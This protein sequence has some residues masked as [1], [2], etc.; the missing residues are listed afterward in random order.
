MDEFK[1]FEYELSDEHSSRNVEVWVSKEN[2]NAGYATIYA[3]ALNKDGGEVPVRDDWF[4]K[5]QKEKERVSTMNIKK[6][7]NH[8]IYLQVLRQIPNHHSF[9]ICIA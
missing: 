3:F 2:G 6:H 7:P 9:C 5:L 1:I 4:A 8:K